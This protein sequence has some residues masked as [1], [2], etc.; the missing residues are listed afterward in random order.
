MPN[1]FQALILMKLGL[2]FLLGAPTGLEQSV[3]ACFVRKSHLRVR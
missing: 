2:F 3:S 1:K